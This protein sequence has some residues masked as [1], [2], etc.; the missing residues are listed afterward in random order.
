MFRYAHT[1]I[2]AKDAK[3]LIAFYKTALHCQSIGE[4]RDLRGDWLDRLTGLPGAH[5]TGEHLLLPGYGG[6][7]PTLEIFQYDAL[8]DDLPRAINRPG[9]AHLAFAAD[10]V[11]AALA[12]VIAAGGGAVGERIA[13]D[14][15]DGRTLHAVYAHDPEGNIIE[16]QSWQKPAETGKKKKA[17]K[18]VLKT[19]RLLLREMTPEDYGALALILQDGQTMTAYEG[20]FTDEETHEWLVRQLD[21]Y[22]TDGFGLW[23]VILKETGEM[24]GQAGLTWQT[25]ENERLPEIGYLFNRA[26][27][28]HGYAAEAAAACK[29]YAFET[30][31]FP[32]VYSIIRDS[33]IPSM[34]V[35]IRN[36]MKIRKRFVKHYRGVDMPHVLFSVRADAR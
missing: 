28:H 6:E 23:A 30:L 24:I 7:H 26:Y 9:I 13:S 15:P 31:G 34:N 18:P 17:P 36:G 8:A 25:V 14:Y 27:W 3:K 12:A 1:N 21:R 29:R 32:E 2:V 16:L 10:D 22:R 11:D 4:T 20:A 19:E 5:I 33:N 35:A